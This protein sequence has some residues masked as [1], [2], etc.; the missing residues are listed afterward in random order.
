MLRHRKAGEA[1]LGSVT[2][3]LLS[4]DDDRMV[5]PMVVVTVRLGDGAL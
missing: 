3:S 5:A 4:A 2:T 1:V